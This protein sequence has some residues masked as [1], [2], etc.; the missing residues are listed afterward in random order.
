MH[1]VDVAEKR[2]MIVNVDGNLYAAERICTHEET[3]L[4][5]LTV[6][7]FYA[8]LTQKQFFHPACTLLGIFSCYFRLVARTSL[9]LG[10]VSYGST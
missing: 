6:P 1:S 5:L 10:V 4:D 8:L 7:I 2:L 9:R 3:K